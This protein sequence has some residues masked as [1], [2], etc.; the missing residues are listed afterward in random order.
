MEARSVRRLLHNVDL[1]TAKEAIESRQR[2]LLGGSL[3]VTSPE[4][5]REL[6]LDPDDADWARIGWDWVR[7]LDAV[8]WERLRAR[9]A[10]AATK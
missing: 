4:G 9:R 7:P 6:G 5:V 1:K 3:F 2:T 8:A 10:T